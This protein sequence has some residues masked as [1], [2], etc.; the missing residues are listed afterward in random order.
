M[1]AL[2]FFSE[3][4]VDHN[5]H[6]GDFNL[7]FK[8]L[9][10]LKKL[11]LEMDETLEQLNVSNQ[12]EALRLSCIAGGLIDI[13]WTHLRTF[14]NLRH[15]ELIDHLDVDEN[16]YFF[17]FLREDRLEFLAID[18]QCLYNTQI[19]PFFSALSNC[20]K[21]K[22][23]D[24]GFSDFED[25][26]LPQCVEALYF[27]LVCREQGSSLSKIMPNAPGVR[28]LYFGVKKYHFSFK[29]DYNLADLKKYFPK[30]ERAKCK[31]FKATED[32]DF[33]FTRDVEEPLCDYFLGYNHMLRRFLTG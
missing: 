24:L 2:I 4:Y 26:I 10:K 9:P 32:L 30:L 29:K 18:T 12:I 21:L 25:I 33:Y 11:T 8:E 20:K 13:D 5:R 28:F 16:N 23:L 6:E 7:A 22:F 19:D 27:V 1:S 31:D 3:L 15:L 14:Q 17:D